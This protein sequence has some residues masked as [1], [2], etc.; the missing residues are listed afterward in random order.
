MADRAETDWAKANPDP[1]V[2][3]TDNLLILWNYPVGGT[4]LAAAHAEAAGRFVAIKC[5]FDPGGSRGEVRVCGHASRSGEEQVND[6]LSRQ[7]AEAVAAH[8]R[9]LGLTGLTVTWAG[10]SSPSDTTGTGLGLA[11][12]RRVEISHFTRSSSRKPVPLE[13][14]PTGAAGGSSTPIGPPAA[15]DTPDL[16]AAFEQTFEANLGTLRT[17]H[18]LV[19]VKVAGKLKVKVKGRQGKVG[20]KA[21]LKDGRL[22]AEA[23]A[24]I[25]EQLKAT[26]GLEEQ[27]GGPPRI[28]FGVQADK[29]VLKPKVGLQTDT[30]FAFV[31]FDV[32]Q[33]A[34]PDIQLGD[35]T[36]TL[37]FTGQVKFD[38]GPSPVMAAKLARYAAPAAGPAAAVGGVIGAAAV[39]NG[40]TALLA[41]R[42]RD[43]GLHKMELWAWRDGAASRM[44]LEILGGDATPLY[45]QQ[46]LDWRKLEGGTASAFEA[47]AGEVVALLRPL[48]ARER[49]ALRKRWDGQFAKGLGLGQWPDVRENVFMALGGYDTE[50]ESR[51]RV[52]AL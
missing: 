49:E 15:A 46:K 34:L 48:E 27:K 33:Q 44:A 1:Q 6:T 32:V 12:N 23:E 10:S 14:P 9:R 16:S 7:R 40:G 8:L 25:A 20:G 37:D 19:D 35:T 36:I 22:S 30:K 39:I 47:G 3:E 26:I 4:A 18:L 52:S 28:K 31:S 21:V 2:Q 45:E 42:A 13:P 29:A 51:P 41:Q 38:M 17:A 43:E 50:G 24:K 5:V 11:R